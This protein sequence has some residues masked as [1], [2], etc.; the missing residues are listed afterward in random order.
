MS[1]SLILWKEID[2]LHHIA[3]SI[4]VYNNDIGKLRN[5]RRPNKCIIKE[6]KVKELKELSYSYAYPHEHDT[7]GKKVVRLSISGPQVKRFACAYAWSHVC[8]YTRPIFHI[9]KKNIQ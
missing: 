1:K 6:F 4:S 7:S 5:E 8:T 3:Y 2:I 9:V